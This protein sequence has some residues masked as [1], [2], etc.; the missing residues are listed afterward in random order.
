MTRP[1]PLIH[2]DAHEPAMHPARLS[3]PLTPGIYS[4]GLML[5]QDLHT[6]LEREEQLDDAAIADRLGRIAV[7][8]SSLAVMAG[9]QAARVRREAGL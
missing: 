5:S 2:R 1:A 7:A 3:A 9:V 6:L 4:A 8:A